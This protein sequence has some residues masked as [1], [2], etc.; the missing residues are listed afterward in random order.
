M[1]SFFDV[2]AHPVS[3]F[4]PNSLKIEFTLYLPT[5]V[6]YIFL[7]RVFCNLKMN[8]ALRFFL[9]DFAT[10]VKSAPFSSISDLLHLLMVPSPY[11]FKKGALHNS[12][13]FHAAYTYNYINLYN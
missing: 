4:F 11:A 3:Q 9:S 12:L 1:L 5:I 8:G 10:C 2:C 6:I 7:N 13:E